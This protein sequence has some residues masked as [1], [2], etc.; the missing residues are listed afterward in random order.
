MGPDSPQ[1]SRES[2][3]GAQELASPSGDLMGVNL[4]HG[5]TPKRSLWGDESCSRLDFRE[6]LKV[7]FM[8][9]GFWPFLVKSR[10]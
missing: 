8:G 1:P 4:G 7:F 5:A 6:S 10:M 3:P 2:F 9:D